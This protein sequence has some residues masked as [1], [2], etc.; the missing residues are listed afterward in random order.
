MSTEDGIRVQSDEQQLDEPQLGGQFFFSSIGHVQYKPA[1]D[2]GSAGGDSEIEGVSYVKGQRIYIVAK[3]GETNEQTKARADTARK[4]FTNSKYLNRVVLASMPLASIT[5]RTEESKAKSKFPFDQGATRVG[6]INP[7]LPIDDE[8]QDYAIGFQLITVP[9][10]VDA[11]ARHKGWYKEPLFDLGAVSGIGETKNRDATEDALFCLPTLVAMRTAIWNALGEDNWLAG[12]EDLKKGN[13]I[14][15]VATKSTKLQEAFGMYSVPW[16][17]W[18]EMAQVA[19]PSRKAYYQATKE[20]TDDNGNTRFPYK[21]NR[22]PAI[23]RFFNGEKDAMEEG[24]RQ[25]AAREGGDEKATKSLN[26]KDYASLFPKLSK[27]ARETYSDA[28]IWAG[29]FPELADAAVKADNKP[30]QIALAK[31]YLIT[32][33]DVVLVKNL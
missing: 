2:C 30:K 33:D 31:E 23:L 12:K 4:E 25:I 10:I 14:L 20:V 5:N 24:K 19:D 26:G 9:S 13:D 16:D 11:W 3:K 22:A 18:A 29:A 27:T 8:K 15:V 1:W 17:G 32:A 6:A 21:R 28:D 7:N